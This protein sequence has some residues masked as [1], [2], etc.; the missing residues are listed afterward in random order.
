V[1]RRAWFA[2]FCGGTVLTAAYLL[3]PSLRLGPVF[4]LIAISSPIVILIAVRL[5]KPQTRLP[6][7]LFALGQTFFV[8]GD[9]IT[10]NY[11]R[12]FGTS[13]PF[14]SIGDVFYLS[15]YPC[16]VAGILLLVRRCNACG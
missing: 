16:L 10:Y 6:W 12:F 1:K 11:E 5:W 14:P 7:Y 9:V 4:N 3:V 2:Y 8:A 15:V 13:L